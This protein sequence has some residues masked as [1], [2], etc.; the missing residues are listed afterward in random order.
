MRIPDRNPLDE[1][2]PGKGPERS[3]FEII[4]TSGSDDRSPIDAFAVEPPRRVQTATAKRFE[5]VPIEWKR[6]ERSERLE[7][8]ERP[9]RSERSERF[10]RFLAGVA[11]ALITVT[12]LN[13]AADSIARPA[14][15]PAHIRV[16]DQE[17]D[18]SSTSGRREQAG[19]F[20]GMTSFNPGTAKAIDTQ[21]PRPA[22]VRQARQV[23]AA[24]SIRESPRSV[25]SQV[26]RRTSTPTELES[27]PTTGFTPAAEARGEAPS[28]A[29]PPVVSTLGNAVAAAA[30]LPTPAV[31]APATPTP[32]AVPPPPVARG[33]APR[34]AVESV[35]GRYASAFSSLDAQGAKAVWPSVNQR[36][37]ERAFG[38]LEEQ[39]FNLGSC[40]IMVLPPRALA[41]CSGSARYTPKVGNRRERT[42]SRHWTFRLA[43]SGQDWSIESVE[44]R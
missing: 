43:Q 36:N 8:S 39:E 42:E 32:P 4:D 28:P 2:Q 17:L 27:A 7:R 23:P 31:T 41:Q 13:W 30:P 26:A 9:E 19:R 29:P 18:V 14:D 20:G 15:T 33:I 22:D 1:F 38:N 40:D 16:A 24:S 35:L 12:A 11:V 6:F 21:K 10:V 37:L 5:F 44:S 25:A 3:K 34:A